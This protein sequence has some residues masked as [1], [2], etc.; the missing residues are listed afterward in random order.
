[1]P[2]LPTNP[3]V[4]PDNPEGTQYSI[5]VVLHML[6]MHVWGLEEIHSHS[7]PGDAAYFSGMARVLEGLRGAVKYLSSLDAKP[8]NV[9][10]LKEGSPTD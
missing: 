2:E 8:D 10:Q 9:S 1:M 7:S 4:E 3:F 5:D 6:A